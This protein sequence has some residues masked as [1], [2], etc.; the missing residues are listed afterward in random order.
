MLFSTA[1]VKKNSNEASLQPGITSIFRTLVSEMIFL[2]HSPPNTVFSF[3]ARPD[4]GLKSHQ[5]RAE[6][7]YHHTLQEK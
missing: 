1:I 3:S 7:Q 2:P 4:N 6:R 5:T